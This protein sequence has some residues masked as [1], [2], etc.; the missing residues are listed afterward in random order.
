MVDEVS[1]G[2]NLPARWGLQARLIGVAGTHRFPTTG[3]TPGALPDQLVPA[4]DDDWIFISPLVRKAEFGR[5][6]S[7]RVVV[8]SLKADGERLK[9]EGSAS[10][11]RA[12]LEGLQP[13]DVIRLCP[14]S[15]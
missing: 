15:G 13:G 10:S 11:E 5:E 4:S 1:A 3:T 6:E 9:L 8:R 14:A 7:V 2:I 12:R